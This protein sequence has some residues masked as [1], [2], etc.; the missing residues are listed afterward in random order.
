M[1]KKLLLCLVLTVALMIGGIDGVYATEDGQDCT[2]LE[3]Q[4]ILQVMPDKSMRGV[5]TPE[6]YTI[7]LGP[8]T[9]E[10]TVARLNKIAPPFDWTGAHIALIV[11]DFGNGPVPLMLVVRPENVKDCK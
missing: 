1:L 6:E 8:E 3:G 4:K 11:I 10:K 7:T 5:I 2:V 9:A